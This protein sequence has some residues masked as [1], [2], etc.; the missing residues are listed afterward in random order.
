MNV[1]RVI[2]MANR[3]DRPVLEAALEGGEVIVDVLMRGEVLA[4]VPVIGTAI[5]ICK[6]ADAI[7]DKAFAAKLAQFVRNLDSMSEE[8]RRKLREK[9]ASAP[10]EAQKLGETLLFVIERVTDLDKPLLLAQ[11]FL[12]YLDDV[13][14]SDELRRLSQAVDTAFADDLKQLLER[15]KLPEKSDELWL[16]CLVPSGLTRLVAGQTYDE[17][18]RLYYEVTPFGNK[19]RNAYFYGRKYTA[20]SASQR[21]PASGRR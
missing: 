18:G 13:L 6:A 8:H 20:N 10:H 1:S 19:L 4:E 9:V 5:K 21:T 2:D 16:E 12:A 11:L 17:L 14:S 15:H 3:E 7:R